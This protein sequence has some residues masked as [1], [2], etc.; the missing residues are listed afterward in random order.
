M[1]S[2]IPPRWNPCDCHITPHGLAHA[3]R[4]VDKLAAAIKKSVQHWQHAPALFVELDELTETAKALLTPPCDAHTFGRI[5]EVLLRRLG[6]SYDELMSGG[7]A[8]KKHGY[9]HTLQ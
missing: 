9:S 5:C 6:T 1:A 3:R 2:P 4:E 8:D 7:A